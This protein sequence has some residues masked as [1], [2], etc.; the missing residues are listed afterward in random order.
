MIIILN[1]YWLFKE[2]KNTLKYLTIFIISAII[3]T[4]KKKEGKRYDNSY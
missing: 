2:K 4:E 1:I 3:N